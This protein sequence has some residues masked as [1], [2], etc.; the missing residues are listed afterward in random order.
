MTSI[1]VTA[2][3]K[4]LFGLIMRRLPLGSRLKRELLDVALLQLEEAAYTR[5]RDQDF[6]RKAS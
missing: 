6:S 1:G 5:L 3:A 4:R 2:F